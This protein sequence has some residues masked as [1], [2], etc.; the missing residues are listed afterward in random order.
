MKVS[1]SGYYKWL[2]HRN[3]KKQYQMDRDYLIGLVDKYHQKHPSWGYRRINGQIRH[4]IGWYVSDNLV[5]K[6]CKYLGIK[7]Q[8]RKRKWIKPGNEHIQFPN[9]VKNKWSVTKPLELIC[10]D[11]TCIRHRSK[12][13]DVVLYLDAF[14][15]EIIAYGYTSNHNSIK[16]YYDGLEGYLDKIKRIEY[17]ST[18]HSDQGIVYSSLAFKNA[19]SNYNILRSMSRVGTPTDNPKMESINGWIKDEICL[20]FNI[21]SYSNF[22]TFLDDYIYYYNNERLA[23]SLNY[24]TPIQYKTELGF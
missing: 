10:T 7:S 20:D 22:K 9:I 24:K 13:Y 11:M 18:L 23:Y 19:H 21:D 12:L 14:N 3:I 17:Q 4:D 16:P 5:H 8:A 2:K 15:N 1:R 6:C